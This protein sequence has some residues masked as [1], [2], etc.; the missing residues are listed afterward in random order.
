MD[1]FETLPSIVRVD[2]N[3]LGTLQLLGIV[4]PDEEDAPQFIKDLIAHAYSNLYKIERENPRF[5]HYTQQEAI[6]EY[7]T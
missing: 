1:D 5:G 2:P 7:R 6:A 4:D 3:A